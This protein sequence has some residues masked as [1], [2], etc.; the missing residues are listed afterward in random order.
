MISNT[1][2]ACGGVAAHY[3]AR[4]KPLPYNLLAIALA[5]QFINQ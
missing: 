1:P 4:D 5:L 3:S 2:S